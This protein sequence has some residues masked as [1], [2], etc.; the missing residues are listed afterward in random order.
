MDFKLLSSD[1]KQN[2][3]VAGTC[4]FLSTV[5]EGGGDNMYVGD[6]WFAHVGKGME[7]G[8]TEEEKGKHNLHEYM[9][10]PALVIY[11]KGSRYLMSWIAKL[12][13][14]FPKGEAN[15]VSSFSSFIATAL[16]PY[17][18]LLI[19]GNKWG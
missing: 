8:N 13:L 16:R 9:A 1:A 15:Q 12:L 19:P 7:T 17:Q 6:V 4:G 14:L 11:L 2:R 10:S 3:E 5:M 18:I